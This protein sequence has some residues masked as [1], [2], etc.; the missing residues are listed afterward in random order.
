MLEDHVAGRGATPSRPSE[1]RRDNSPTS[2]ES[3]QKADWH[4]L[5]SR[6]RE[7]GKP[8]RF[9]LDLL[10]THEALN[11]PRFGVSVLRLLTECYRSAHGG[12]SRGCHGCCRRWTRE[13][14]FG[15]V[16]IVEFLNIDGASLVGICRECWARPDRLQIAIG[17]SPGPSPVLD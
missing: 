1:D 8:L 9:A 12:G 10:P 14:L 4:A 7:L 6:I 2:L 13:R 3:Q 11:D 15:A 17:V 5:Q 16:E